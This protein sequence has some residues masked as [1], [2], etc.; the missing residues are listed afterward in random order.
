MTAPSFRAAD[1]ASALGLEPP[2]EEQ[3]RVIESPLAP[4]LV[5]A[6]AGS[7]KTETMAGRV[8]WLVANGLVVADQVL[9]LTFTRKAAAELSE[10]IGLRLRALA[11]RGIGPTQEAGVRAEVSTYN[12][13]AASLVADHG[14]RLGVEPGSRLLGE[15]A[16]WQLAYDVVESWDGDG[17]QGTD[18]AALDLGIDWLVGAV[19]SLAGQCAEHLVEPRDL[20]DLLDDLEQRAASLPKDD[21]GGAPAAPTKTG[22]VASVLSTAR[23]RRALVPVVEAY[24]R[25]KRELE[26]LDFG[27]QVRLGARLAAVP[28]VAAGERARFRVVLLDEYQDTSHAQLSLLRSLFA[29]GH[30][31]TAVGDP[32]QS[33]YGWRGASA[34]N[35]DHFPRHFPLPDGSPAPVQSLSTSWRNDRVAL[36]LANLVSAPLRTRAAVPVPALVARPGAGEGVVEV[37]W[38]ATQ[39]DEA[40]AVASRVAELWKG[41]GGPTVAVLCR[42]RKQFPFLENALR[43]QGLP[44]EVVGLGGLLD[45]P[46]V[47]DVVATLRVLHDPSRGDALVRLMTGPRWRIGPRDLMALGRWAR[48]LSARARG[49]G[50]DTGAGLTS[51]ATVV[52][53]PDAVD[54]SS[55]VDALDTLPPRGW[56]PADGPGL[57]PTGHERLTHLAAE[58]A[59][60]RRSASLPLAELV[61]EVERTLLLEIELASVTDS[62]DAA[63]ARSQLD[64][65]TDVAAS[66]TDTADRPSLGGFLSWLEAAAQKE[67]GLDQEQ[68]EPVVAGDDLTASTTAVQLLTVHAAKGLEW[69]V[70]AVPG[71]VERKFPSGTQ[72]RGRDSAPGWPT[73]IGDLPYSLRGDRDS[74]PVWRWQDPAHLKALEQSL[75][76]FKADCG[77]HEVTEERRL[78]YVAFTR[79]RHTLL[80]SGFWWD[81]T[82]KPRVASR[83]L[84]EVVDGLADDARVRLVDVTAADLVSPPV[85]EPNP[86]RDRVVTAPWPYD[87]L[88][89]RRAALEAAA[90]AV[91]SVGPV[92]REDLD[93]DGGGLDGEIA[94]LLLERDLAARGGRGGRVRLP[95]HLSAS[96]AVQLAADPA[97]LALALRRPMPS[98]P[99]PSTRRGT[100]FHAWMEQRLRS[101]ALID[102][103]DLPGAGD[104]T[105][106]DR[107]LADLQATFEASEWASRE[108]VA[109]EVDVETP[110]AGMVLRGRIDAVFAGAPVFGSPTAATTSTGRTGRAPAGQSE[111]LGVGYDV[112]DWK[113]GTPPTGHQLQAAA[114]QLAVYRLAW[115]RLERVPVDQVG[116]AFFYVSTGQTLRPADG[117]DEQDLVDLVT[118]VEIDPGDQVPTR[119]QR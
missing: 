15:A 69:D 118:G 57:S 88:G 58:L 31:V 39:E 113:T 101:E 17:D 100:A 74:L 90:D 63:L 79:P 85:D 55:I 111:L 10:R 82:T 26:T 27:D 14:L 110:V 54:D 44:V 77:E 94:R 22:G 8:V 1:L 50:S 104:D 92:G 80:L 33:I 24:L 41:T 40:A 60:L 107:E 93:A 43:A 99:R 112:V 45:R 18:L 105:A 89:A 78:A 114:V 21:K 84:R 65:F 49:R 23:Q 4:H 75:T 102:L 68:E 12:A 9:G 115:A 5:V 116:A 70:V 52:P 28:D 71:L 91:R 30:A 19:L 97:A 46:E 3:T 13:Y 67:R 47:A 16:G 20:L 86:V 42:Q 51:D 35:L 98:E 29:A 48:S 56:S 106:L 25:R 119:H 117:L 7:G 108:V 87:P 62:D 37:S 59:R 11:R 53:D 64:A 95:T 73:T 96:R 2:T 109:V 72:A 76:D 38:H 61:G 81:E 103:D 32:H 34:A 66:F 6:G 36:D 83:F